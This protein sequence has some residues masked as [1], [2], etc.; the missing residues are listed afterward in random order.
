MKHKL[1]VLQCM[2][3]AAHPVNVLHHTLALF[4]RHVV[5]LH[6]ISP[7]CLCRL[8]RHVRLSDELVRTEARRGN[9]RDSYAAL[10][11]K[12]VALLGMTETSHLTEHLLGSSLRLG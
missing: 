11:V 7:V 12:D 3:D 10:K 8:A 6:P 2:P 4:T 9:R 1:V 5:E